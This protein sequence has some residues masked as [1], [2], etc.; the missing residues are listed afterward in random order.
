MDRVG[1]FFGD[2][3]KGVGDFLECKKKRMEGIID[4]LRFFKTSLSTGGGIGICFAVCILGYSHFAISD[5][6]EISFIE[7]TGIFLVAIVVAMLCAY[8]YIQHK[9]N[10]TDTLL[11]GIASVVASVITCIFYVVSMLL[12]FSFGVLLVL[13]SVILPIVGIWHIIYYQNK[14]VKYEEYNITKANK[15]RDEDLPKVMEKTKMMAP[16]VT[17]L[18]LLLYSSK[19]IIILITNEPPMKPLL[20]FLFTGLILYMYYVIVVEFRIWILKWMLQ[21]ISKT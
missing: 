5:R 1:N 13:I 14:T 12:H 15:Q 3:G 19:D 21:R 8:L 6:I 20:Y 10:K 9:R 16:L 18:T 17:A 2:A 11:Y 4:S 7:V